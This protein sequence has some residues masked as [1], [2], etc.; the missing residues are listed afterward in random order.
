MPKYIVLYQEPII[1]HQTAV[2]DHTTKSLF[3]NQKIIW[4]CE[5]GKSYHW[6]V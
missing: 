6:L 1:K 2:K 4:S 5:P 3:S